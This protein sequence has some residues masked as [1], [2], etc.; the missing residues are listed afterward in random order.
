MDLK[1]LLARC[2]FQDERRLLKWDNQKPYT[3]LI[4]MQRAER[5]MKKASVE[6]VK[7]KERPSE[8]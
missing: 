3:K 5:A 7:V 1:E 2:I 8:G 6:N 4:F